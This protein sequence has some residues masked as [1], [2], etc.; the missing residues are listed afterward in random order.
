MAKLVSIRATVAFDHNGTTVRKDQ[1]VRVGAVEAAILIHKRKAV[2]VSTR[3]SPA[4]ASSK[5]TRA[6]VPS[7][8]PASEPTS[9][10]GELESPVATGRLET[11]DLTPASDVEQVEEPQTTRR[12]GRGQ[13]NRQDMRA[14][15]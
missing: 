13:Y 15:S 8:P 3:S 4:A 9:T 5:S 10:A 14:D 6:D 1:V 12:R 2:L 7:K 11:S